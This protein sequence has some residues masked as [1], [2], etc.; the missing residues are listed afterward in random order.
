M[1]FGKPE[2]DALWDLI[3]KAFETQLWNDWQKVTDYAGQFWYNGELEE[4]KRLVSAVRHKEPVFAGFFMIDLSD[5]IKRR[6]KA[7]EENAS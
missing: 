6:L 5:F 3:D 7:D 4:F 1:K 2:Y